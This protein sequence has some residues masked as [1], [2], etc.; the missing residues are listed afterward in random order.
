MRARVVVSAV[1]L[2]VLFVSVLFPRFFS[3]YGF[4]EQNRDFVFVPPTRIHLMDFQGR[5]HWHPFVC[6]WRPRPQAFELYD[7]DPQN[8]FPLRLFVRGEADKGWHLF[9]VAAPAKCFLMGTDA[10]GRDVFSRFL[11]GGQISLFAGML[12]AMLSLGIGTALGT[13]AG[14]YGT[15]VDAVIMRTA[16]VFLALPWIYLLFGLRAFLPLNIGPSQA[17]LLII[18]TIGTVGWAR[19]AKLV[20]A[21]VL[22]GKERSYVLAARMFGG[23]DFY[24]L[25]RHILPQAS[26]LILTQAALLIPQYVLCEVTLSFLG[27]GIGE[28]AP[29][30]G[31]MLSDLQQYH[32]M[33]SYWWMWIP[34]LAMLP[35]F[36][37]F[38]QIADHLQPDAD[39]LIVSESW[40]TRASL[41]T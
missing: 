4:A 27:L 14:F 23:S 7:E 1:F 39:R 20:R 22:S 41:G 5:F 40:T 31:R 29:S 24:V 26:G 21:V 12:A 35:I 32:V 13:I 19:P 38:I 30:W 15:W 25:R 16:E 2:T 17:F 36:F 28:P 37:C 8:C 3:P 6:Q 18:A 11:Y 9:G 33:I 34:A 10:Y